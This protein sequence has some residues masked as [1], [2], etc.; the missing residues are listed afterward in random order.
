[1]TTETE[2]SSAGP[3]P[4]ST[5]RSSLPESIVGG[6]RLREGVFGLGLVAVASTTILRAV[7]RSPVADG[8]SST[9]VGLLR[10]P[11]LLVVLGVVALV[12]AATARELPAAVGF[13][14]VGVFALLGSVVDAAFLPA[15][16]AVVLGGSIA[17]AWPLS[18]VALPSSGVGGPTAS[19]AVATVLV[20]GT[21]V[22]LAGAAGVRPAVVR[23]LGGIALFTGLFA[24][25]LWV[26]GDA[27][28]IATGA[29]VGAFVAGVGIQLPVITG[30]VLLSGL[31]VVG[32]PFAVV[33]AGL[34]GAV[35]GLSAALRDRHFLTAI[36]VGLVVAAGVPA[37]L[38]AATAAMLGI[39]AMATGEVT[40]T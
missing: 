30:A 1:M 17:T 10:D 20:I 38:P 6:N 21:A 37:S 15:A 3:T 28:D 11:V 32:I 34:A 29:F 5:R 18:R 33:V 9:V 14:G 19:W 13:T 26:G 31:S 4:P 39:T 40:A 22:S 2:T 16:V 7:A 12:L 25:P 35:T 27:I 24:V 8:L 36:G 23:P